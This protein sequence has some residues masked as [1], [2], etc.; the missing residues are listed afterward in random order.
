MDEPGANGAEAN[1]G[2][3]GGIDRR[4]GDGVLAGSERN[5]AEIFKHEGHG[6]IEWKTRV[7]APGHLADLCGA[8]L[9]G[10]VTGNAANSFPRV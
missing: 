7:N 9:D 10:D 4:A 2:R 3:S 5:R 1:A 8:P 6:S